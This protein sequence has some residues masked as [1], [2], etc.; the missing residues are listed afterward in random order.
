MSVTPVRE[1]SLSHPVGRARSKKE[2]LAIA[3]AVGSMGTLGFSIT[4][5]L[6]PD[7][8]EAFGVSRG[9]IGLVQA[10]VSIPGVLFSALIGYFA[11]RFGRRRVVLISLIIFSTF[12]VAGF[13]TRSFWGLVGARFLQ[14]IGTSG[15]LGL[16]IVLIG[17][18]FD[19]NDRARAMGINMTGL[20]IVNMAGPALSGALATGGTFRPFLVFAVGFPLALWATRMPKDTPT[21]AT[22]SPLIHAG[23]AVKLMRRNRTFVNFVGLLIATIA[24]VI[25]LHGLGLTTTPLFLDE[26]FGTGVAMRGVVIATFQI[27]VIITAI[28][29]G[30]LRNRFGATT[31]IT[32][33]F[34]LMA[35]GSTVTA[36]APAVWTVGLG[37][38]IAGVGFGLFVPLA[39][40]YAARAG[41]A[42]YRGVTVLTW[43]TVV[44][45]GQVT[46]PPTSSLLAD[47]AGPRA[48]FAGAAI[49]M[50][51]LAILWRPLR[52]RANRQEPVPDEHV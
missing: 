33:A 26:E 37:L 25:L 13:I 36:T 52:E 6:L 4:A 34:A 47:S 9:A 51:L 8:A 10:S 39:Q 48:T 24:N 5:P 32:A 45:I 46:G 17:D 40:D 28:R 11:D 42:A 16:S 41:T 38:A 18:Q 19:G 44:R 27:G 35:L 2:M 21:H 29:I 22:A 15:I 50:T 20:T 1:R 49:A 43:V 23:D 14:G 3:I 7:L 31:I 12:G 30:S